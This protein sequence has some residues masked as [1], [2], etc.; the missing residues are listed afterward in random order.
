MFPCFAKCQIEHSISLK[1]KPVFFTDSCASSSFLSPRN[2]LCSNLKQPR[3]PPRKDEKEN[4][5]EDENND[6]DEDEEGAT[7]TRNEPPKSTPCVTFHCIA[8][9]SRPSPL[10]QGCPMDYCSKTALAHVPA[11]SCLSVASRRRLPPQG[12][13]ICRPKIAAMKYIERHQM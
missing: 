4:D 1:P 8:E 5:D 12:G 2:V 11:T 3:P 6:E 7:I 9:S 13:G 10:H